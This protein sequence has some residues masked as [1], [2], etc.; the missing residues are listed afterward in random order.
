MRSIE[1]IQNRDRT[2]ND[3]RSIV[4]SNP[5]QSLLWEEID[6]PVPEMSKS[7]N[8]QPDVNEAFQIDSFLEDNNQFLVAANELL[9]H[10]DEH[11]IRERETFIKELEEQSKTKRINKAARPTAHSSFER[12]FRNNKED[13]P[14]HFLDDLRRFKRGYQISTRDILENLDAMLIEDAKDWCLINENSWR[15]LSDFFKEFTNT[16]R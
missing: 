6:L 4:E 2:T 12:E 8:H 9:K 5:N 3:N 11:V 1:A 15:T 14:A 13:I 10:Y 7:T 16:Y